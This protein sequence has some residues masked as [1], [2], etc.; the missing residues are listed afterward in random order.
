MIVLQEFAR[1]L[2]PGGLLVVT[3]SVQRGDRPENDATIENFTDLNEPHYP[4][5]VRFDFGVEFKAAGLRPHLK[6][7]QSSTKS[8]SATKPP[9]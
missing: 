4:A 2:K 1:V 5:Y 6:S 9:H 7:L 8:V 3:D